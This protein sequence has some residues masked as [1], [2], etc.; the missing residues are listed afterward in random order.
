MEPSEQPFPPARGLMSWRWPRISLAVLIV[1]ALLWS[2][3]WFYVPPLVVSEAEKAVTQKLG[4]RLSLGRVAFNPWTLELTI[5]DLALA[6][7]AGGAPPLLQVKRI[8]ANAAITSL[9]HLAPVIDN[10]DVD[11]P[12]LRLTRRAD[13]SYDIDDLLRRT[14]ASPPSPQPARFAVHNI[15]VRAGAVDFVDMPM[16]ATRRIRDLELGIPFLSTL[17]SEREINVEPHLAFSLDGN[18]FDSAAATAPW[19]EQGKGEAKVHLD[20]FDIAPYLVYLPK[21]MPARPQSALVTADLLLDFERHPKLSLRVSG[22]IE[23]SGIKVV[24]DAS[25][26]LLEAGGIKI[27]VADLRPLEY[28]AHLSRV[29]VDGPHVLAQRNANGRVNLMLAAKESDEGP[30]AVMRVPLPTTAASAAA[31]APSAGQPARSAAPASPW[32]VTLAAL[33]VHAGELDWRDV[34]TTPNAALALTEFSFD[35]QSISWPV[36]APVIFKGE[37]VIG[38]QTEHGKMTFSGQGNAAG[39]TLRVGLDALPLA[40]AGPYARAQLELPFAGTLSADLGFEWKPTPAGPQLKVDARRV[41]L[42]GLV[43]GEAKVPEFGLEQIELLDAHVDTAARRA[44]IGQVALHA[45][46][47]LLVRDKDGSW[48]FMHWHRTAA[49]SAETAIAHPLPASAAPVSARGVAG[50]WKVALGDLAIDKA[51]VAFAD[52]SRDEPVA[53]NLS[54][55]ALRVHG[56]ALDAAGTVPFRVSGRVAVPAGASGKAIGSGVVGSID[57]RGEA[58][59]FSGGVPTSATARLLLKDLPLHLVDP[60]LHAFVDIDVQKAQTSFKGDVAFEHRGNESGPRLR[61]RGDASIDDFIAASAPLQAP[62]ADRAA[63]A[64]NEALAARQLLNWKL[65]SLRGID[66]ALAPGAPAHVAVAETSLTDFFARIVLDER[67]RLNLQDVAR[68][69][70]AA[71]GAVAAASAASPTPAVVAAASAPPLSSPGLAPLFEFGPIVLVNGRVNYTDHFVTPNYSADLS[72]LNGRLGAFTARSLLPGTAPQ[73]ADFELRGRA[74]ETGVLEI[75]GKVNPLAKPLALDLKAKVRDLE[76]SPL[77]PYAI[78]YSGY[79][80]ERGKLSVDLAYL[81]KP[82]GELTASNRIVLNQL[83]FGEKVPGSKGSLPVKLAVAL[84][85]DSHGVIDVDLPV[86]GSINDPQF[87]LGGVIWKAITN[88]IVKVVTAPFRLL[89]SAFGGGSGDELSTVAF[90][91]ASTTLDA[92]AKMR[93]DQVA[94]ALL[95]RPTLGLTVSGESRLDV[96]KEAWKRDRLQQMVRVEKRRRAIGGGANPSAE[97]AVSEAEYPDLLKEVYQRADIVKPKN[98]IGLTKD[99]PTPEMEALLLTS[100]EVPADAMEQLA[101]RR[102]VV[103]RDYLATKDLPSSRLFLGA[104]KTNPEGADWTP[105]ADLKVSVD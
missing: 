1:L 69:P 38:T 40:A 49:S 11:A 20:H 37:G 100:I 66:V 14:A 50:G 35:A 13:G 84:L 74:Q 3:A 6:G 76:L 73:L 7:A 78:K 59:G 99:L 86:G 4:R 81:V 45:P 63:A 92:E 43:L 68:A 33:S 31:S 77:S 12:M 54:D 17:P 15:V 53:L 82:D 32:K 47:L 34:T 103:V 105:R 71:Q 80:I 44:S 67:G 57:V 30:K 48:N 23:V 8:H 96:E 102:G 22:T 28:V 93:L 89:A 79:G 88:L 83:T 64:A 98:V 24:D 27:A 36:D 26:E 70:A 2:A 55:F 42:S 9:L 91:P 16:Q 29:E 104:T 52:R 58:R 90:S 39:A 72:D 51:R 46:R 19:S 101:L 65:L 56:W 41:A 62:A 60:Y 10:L 21:S 85:A 5:D 75:T 97:V 18:H 25:Q 94:K 95:E 87:S 61:L